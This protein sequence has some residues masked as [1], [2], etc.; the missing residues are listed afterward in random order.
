MAL[1][2]EKEIH[3][4]GTEIERGGLTYTELQQ[5]LLDHL[6]CDVEAKMEEGLAF[7]KALEKVKGRMEPDCIRQIQEDTLLLINKKYRLMKKFMFILGMIAPSMLII[8]TIFKIQHWPGAGVMIVLSLFL[9]GAIYLPVFVSVKIRDTRKQGK[10]VNK[11]MYIFGLIAGIVFIAGAMFKLQHWPGAGVMITLS[12]I[13]TVAIFIPIL[14]IQAIREKENQVQ[15]FTVLIFVLSFTAIAFM[16]VA[17]RPSQ[18]IMDSFISPAIE[19]IK[20]ER[21]IEENNDVFIDRFSPLYSE[22]KV[23]AEKINNLSKRTDDLDDYISDIIRTIIVE[24]NINNQEA[25]GEDGS[26]EIFDL[27]RLDNYSSVD[28]ILFGDDENKGAGDE[29]Q[30]VIEDYRELAMAAVGPDFS[31]KIEKAL[32]TNSSFHGEMNRSWLE[33]YFYHQPMIGAVIQL[34]DIQLKI[35]IVEGE[36]LSYLICKLP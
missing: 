14:V 13:V 19:N 33:S 22:S 27:V 25:I 12:G 21:I 20:M 24:A 32:E 10:P 8:G 15:N 34:T 1:L 26:I 5:E 31:H 18:Y 28:Y 30:K 3:F 35:R 2:S 23:L 17:L 36:V 11:P 16:M 29:L 7:V 6:C 9:L 4:L